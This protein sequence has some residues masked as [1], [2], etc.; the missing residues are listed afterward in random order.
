MESYESIVAYTGRIREKAREC[1]FGDQA[2][3]RILIKRCI[4]KRWNLEQF[5]EEAS[6]S[7]DIGEQVKDMKDDHKVARIG[8]QAGKH[9]RDYKFT[10]GKQAK[11]HGSYTKRDEPKQ[12]WKKSG[13]MCGYCGKTDSHKPG[14]N[15]PAFGKQCLKCG[16]YNHFAICCKSGKSEKPG[17]S[18]RNRNHRGGNSQKHIKKTSD[19]HPSSDSDDEFISQAAKHVSHHVKRVRSGKNQDTVLIRIGDIDASVE[20][21]SGATANIMDEYQFRALQHRSNS[22]KELKPS[23]ET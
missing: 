11:A 14:Q 18:N 23:N 6:Q 5:I 19:D 13:K 10:G 4:Q 12:E 8:P 15:C 7:E 3:D 21:D 16:K 1:E 22:V 2:D 20:P 9:K 17:R